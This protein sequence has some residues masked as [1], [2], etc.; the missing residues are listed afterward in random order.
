MAKSLLLFL[1]ELEIDIITTE[2]GGIVL[3]LAGELT[4]VVALASLALVDR[5]LADMSSLPPS[6]SP[7]ASPL[8]LLSPSSFLSPLSSLRY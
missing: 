7:L 3:F 2:A 8:S 4:L 6:P 5:A 1:Y